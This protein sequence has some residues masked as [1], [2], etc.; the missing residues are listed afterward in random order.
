MFHRSMSLGRVYKSTLSSARSQNLI[1]AT[2]DVILFL[3][4]KRN[5][6]KYCKYLYWYF[7]ERVSLWLLLT[8]KH[9]DFKRLSSFLWYLNTCAVRAMLY[10]RFVIATFALSRILPI[11]L[12]TRPP[13]ERSIKAWP[14]LADANRVFLTFQGLYSNVNTICFLPK[15]VVYLVAVSVIYRKHMI[16]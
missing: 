4:I 14:R 8:T 12:K 13:I 6:F 5:F 1:M 3:Q 7:S 9:K 16:V 11:P 15:N 2:A 10:V